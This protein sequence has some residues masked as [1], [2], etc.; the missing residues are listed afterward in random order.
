MF[1]ITHD[2][3]PATIYVTDDSVYAVYDDADNSD[4]F[5][6]AELDDDSVDLEA[7]LT[8]E[9]GSE[10]SLEILAEVGVI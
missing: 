10:M 4:V 5:F 7:D 3:R 9:F 6:H 1:P 8:A 2:N